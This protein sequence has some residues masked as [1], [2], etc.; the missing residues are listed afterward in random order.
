MNY[1]KKKI[2]ASVDERVEREKF[3][4]GKV[5]KNRQSFCKVVGF[6]N[7]YSDID[8]VAKKIRE[9][10]SKSNNKIFLEIGSTTWFDWLEDENISALKIHAINISKE[11]V[12][13]GEHLALQAKKNKPLFHIMDAHKLLFK[14]NSFDVVFGKGILHHLELELAFSEIKRV[15]KPGGMMVFLE[16]LNINPFSKL[17][18]N[19]TPSLRTVDEEAFG[20]KQL[21]LVEKY[22]RNVHYFPSQLSIVPLG[23][24]SKLLFKSQKNFLTYFGYKFDDLLYKLFPMLKFLY[25]RM[26]IVSY[27]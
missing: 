17:F 3:G 24:L 16:P 25:R 6:A 21:K 15:L 22:F 8:V 27:K 7:A 2:N 1:K 11:E 12:E 19:L 14:D 10:L 9:Y 18:R 26:L 4:Y 23:V 20:F 13:K 5:I